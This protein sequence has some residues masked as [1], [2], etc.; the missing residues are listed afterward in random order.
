[1]LSL[2]ASDNVHHSLHSK[3]IN[4]S[5]IIQSSAISQFIQPGR[6][7][8]VLLVHAKNFNARRSTILDFASAVAADKQVTAI[9][10]CPIENGN[11]ITLTVSI[12]GFKT[13]LGEAVSMA[14]SARLKTLAELNGAEL[15]I[16]LG[17]E[18]TMMS[19]HSKS[20]SSQDPFHWLVA[21]GDSTA[22]ST[23]PN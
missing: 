13:P 10:F 22:A 20:S 7:L 21:M 14:D 11:I 15:T 9:P 2:I 4:G 18:D 6:T 1:M 16:V 12:N 23:K 17:K 19:M 5:S 8:S 3:V